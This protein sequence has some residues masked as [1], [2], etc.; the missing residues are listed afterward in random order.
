MDERIKKIADHYG[1]TY[2]AEK[3][4]EEMAELIVA[5]KHRDNRYPL[6]NNTSFLEE[7]ADVKIM[8]DQLYYLSNHS[9]NV[10]RVI[11]TKLDRQ[12]KRIEAEND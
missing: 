6:F 11:V 4:I 3:A 8:I 5:I 7:L 2:Q 12:I 1:L 9:G 10:R